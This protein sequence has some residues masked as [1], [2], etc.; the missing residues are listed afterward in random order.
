MKVTVYS[1]DPVLRKPA[2]LG[3]AMISDLWAGRELAWRLMLRNINAMYRQ[4]ALGYVWAFLPPIF[5][6]GT[7]IL[8][9]SGGLFTTSDT[10]IPYA[11]WA[12]IGAFLWQVFV[13]AFNAPIRQVSQAKAMLTKINF[14]REALLVAGI[15]ETLFNFVV[16]LAIIVPVLL[17]F[18]IM[19]T[20]SI[21]IFPIALSMLIAIGT[22]LGVLLTPIAVLYQDFE[23][24]IPLLLP[25]LMLFSGVVV[26]IPPQGLGRTIALAN[27]ILPLLETCRDSLTGQSLIH[28][29]SM[30]VISVVIL[31]LLFVGWIIFRLA[32]PHLIARLGG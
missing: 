20:S 28:L 9:R 25:F 23:K 2:I 26:P 19:P 16:R 14:P 1:P 3:K 5:A 13:D 29:M 11:A 15:G 10:A 24:G 21:L 7:F 31:M 17:Y 18:R 4:T 27:P 30:A 12:I 6:A 22:M 8:L 32:M